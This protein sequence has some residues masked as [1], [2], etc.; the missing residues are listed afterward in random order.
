MNHNPIPTEL[1]EYLKTKY[2]AKD[3]QSIKGGTL[4]DVAKVTTDNQS[5][6]VKWNDALMFPGMFEAEAEGLKLITNANVGFAPQVIETGEVE[7]ASFLLLEYIKPG[8]RTYQSMEQLG[9]RLAQM[10][11][12]T[13]TQFGLHIN[14]YMGIL[15][16]FNK[17]SDT[18]ADF[19]IESR[20]KPL[21][22]KAFHMRLL[23]LEDV[24]KFVELYQKLPELFPAE[25]PALLH[26]DLW[27]GNVMVN[28]LEQPILVDPACYFGNR[29]ADIAM[30]MLFGGFD[31]VFYEAY[32]ANYPLE[33]GWQER[34]SLWNL[35]PLL[36]HLLLFGKAYKSELVQSLRRNV[37]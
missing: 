21:V 16:Q 2:H 27:N 34:V 25:Q 3:A 8:F 37:A 35:Y 22:N 1:W 28:E 7:D 5:F 11:R 4:N 23:E 31:R 17:P 14:N 33:N 9:E 19:F 36:V 18:W 10:H 29:E 32:H 13:Q 20:L 24:S 30:T 6:F 15:Q 26:G 12:Q